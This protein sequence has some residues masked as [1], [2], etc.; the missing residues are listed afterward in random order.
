MDRSFVHSQFFICVPNFS[1]DIVMPNYYHRIRGT[2]EMDTLYTIQYI[3]YAERERGK[4]V[5][6]FIYLILICTQYRVLFDVFAQFVCLSVWM[7]GWLLCVRAFYCIIYVACVCVC[8]SAGAVRVFFPYLIHSLSLCLSVCL[9]LC[10]PVH[11][12]VCI[13]LGS[14][15]SRN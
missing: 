13:C 12:D 4:N 7:T 15:N 11:V 2:R 10:L 1:N 6:V 8:V 14:F 3:N 9:S 5:Y